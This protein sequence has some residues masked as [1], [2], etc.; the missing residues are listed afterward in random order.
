MYLDFICVY[1]YIL[2]TSSGC[3]VNRQVHQ[4]FQVCPGANVTSTVGCLDGPNG[5]WK[6]PAKK[7]WVS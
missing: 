7:P 1:I 4:R 6:F 5:M 3:M 2:Y